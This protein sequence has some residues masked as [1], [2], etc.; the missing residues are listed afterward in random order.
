MQDQVE[1]DLK[2]ET[3]DVEDNSE[4]ID[5][6]KDRI[7]KAVLRLQDLG[8]SNVEIQ[9]AKYVM[10][11]C[12]VGYIMASTLFEEEAFQEDEDALLKEFD[13]YLS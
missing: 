2:M 9:S 12:F 6:F 7:D 4:E 5:D 13:K 3:G 8:C 11:R 1:P 10:K